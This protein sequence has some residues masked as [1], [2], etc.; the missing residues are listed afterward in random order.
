MTVAN[1]TYFADQVAFNSSASGNA[2]TDASN[3]VPVVLDN[4]GN[5]ILPITSSQEALIQEAATTSNSWLYIIAGIGIIW[6][7]MNQKK[8]GKNW[9]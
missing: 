3:Y 4:K 7:W 2:E 8:S 6:W 1:S 9:L 5:V